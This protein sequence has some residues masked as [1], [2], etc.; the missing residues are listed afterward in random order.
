[1]H[2]PHAAF[3]RRTRTHCTR[4]WAP[5]PAR[6]ASATTR[7]SRSRWTCSSSTTSMVHLEMMAALLDALPHA[8]LVL[9]GDKDQARL[10]GSGRRARRP[11]LR[12]RRR[13]R[14]SAATLPC[15]R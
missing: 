2:G 8:H 10:G 12:R 7:A 15:A 3:R 9:L 1:M 5:G 14:Y 13:R 11:V 6:A 4:C